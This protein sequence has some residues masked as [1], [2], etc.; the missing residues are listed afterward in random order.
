MYCEYIKKFD[1]MVLNWVVDFALKL[2]KFG[3]G[4]EWDIGPVSWLKSK[5]KSLDPLLD[6]SPSPPKTSQNNHHLTLGDASLT[7]H[8]QGAKA[9]WVSRC[10]SAVAFL[11]SHGINDIFMTGIECTFTE[12]VFK[13]MFTCKLYFQSNVKEIL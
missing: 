7:L 13:T 10:E 4:L 3:R 12:G 6:A 1:V 11:K 9:T 5:V 8:N 2:D